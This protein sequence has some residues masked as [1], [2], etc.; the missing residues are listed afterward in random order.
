MSA[1]DEFVVSCVESPR[2]LRRPPP[3]LCTSRKR[4]GG[5]LAELL[6]SDAHNFA[7][8]AFPTR[9]FTGAHRYARTPI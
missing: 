1:M 9:F 6:G 5:S 4:A 7:G 2:V 8:T 3:V